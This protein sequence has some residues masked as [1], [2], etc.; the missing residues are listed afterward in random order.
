[1]KTIYEVMRRPWVYP[2]FPYRAFDK[3]LND[4]YYKRPPFRN[5]TG[6]GLV[7]FHNEMHDYSLY[8]E[9]GLIVAAPEAADKWRISRQSYEDYQKLIKP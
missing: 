8:K 6:W 9:A 1:M 7:V 4:V 2:D 5:H 3:N